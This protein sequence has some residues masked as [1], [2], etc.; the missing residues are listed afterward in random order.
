MNRLLTL[1]ILMLLTAPGLQGQ[2]SVA[3]YLD[4]AVK[5]TNS[6]QNLEAI[7]YCTYH[8]KTDSSGSEAYYLRSYN[9]FILGNHKLAHT[10]ASRCIDLQPSN[11][12]AWLL[13]GRIRKSMGNY[14]GAYQDFRRARQLDPV[15]S[16]MYFTK[17]IFSSVLPAS[18]TKTR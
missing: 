16:F 18:Q 4:K 8:I 17:S 9:Y 2:E 11:P 10:D 6:H 1:L 5:L 15:K 12:D 13:R 14:V 3:P 7:L